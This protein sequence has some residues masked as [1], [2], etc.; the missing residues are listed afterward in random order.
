MPS[1]PIFNPHAN[2]TLA[3]LGPQMYCVVVDNA[4]AHP[5]EWR[6]YAASRANEFLD[7]PFNAYPGVQLETPPEFHGALNDFFSQHVR[8]TLGCRR[9]LHAHSRFALVTRKPDELQPRQTIC[10]RDNAWVAPEHINAASVLYLFDDEGLGGTSFY[11][12]RVDPANLLLLVHES[13]TLD[14]ATFSKKYG[15]P[16]AYMRDTNRYFARTATVP[17]AFNR[18]IFYDGGEFHTGDIAAPDRLS[19][20]PARGRL[21][22][23]GFFTCTRM[24]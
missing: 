7:A 8:R 18:M 19:A 21:T 6:D 11:K 4:L 16:R 23:N 10:H 5:E 17:A 14:A 13:G 2:F 9:T 12:P 1:S 22:M 3:S 20:D 24:T 15:V